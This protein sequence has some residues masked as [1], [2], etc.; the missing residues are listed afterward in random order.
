MGWLHRN[1]ARL[2]LEVV[3]A[4]VGAIGGERVAIRFSPYAGFQGS[5]KTDFLELYTYLITEL[6]KK[7]VRFA[8]LSLVEATGDPGALIW[9]DKKIHQDKTLD[10]ILEE[11]DNLSPVIV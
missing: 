9:N 2:T 5:E 10:F 7:D 1:R 11:W 8:Y 3:K 4:V 6:K